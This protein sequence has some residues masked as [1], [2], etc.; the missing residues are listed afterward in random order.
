MSKG[1]QQASQPQPTA[2]KPSNEYYYQDGNLQS[3]RVYDKGAKGYNTNS[4]STPQEQ[5][6]QTNA[7]QFISD[8]SSRIPQ[9]F[10]MT[11]DQL[12]AGVK[13][14]TDPQ[15]AALNN[16]YNQASGQAKSAAS[17][18]GMGN[19]V[20]FNNY[21]AN[22]IEKN[23]AQ[24]LADIAAGGEQMR[25]Q[26]PSQ[27]LAPFVDAFN[28]VNAGLSGQQSQVQANLN[29]SFQGSQATSNL[30]AGLYPN[31]LQAWQLMN[32]QQPKSGFSLF[33]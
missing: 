4:Y 2:P 23:R 1:K 3:S 5:A 8:L 27:R 6:I 29:P 14:Y 21:F 18:R 26:L 24:G 16:S 10:A 9:E 7:T 25:Y 30:Q 19:S 15:V 32:Q 12:D 28:L 11:P 33:G 13:A 22:Q 31:Q 17:A 20:G